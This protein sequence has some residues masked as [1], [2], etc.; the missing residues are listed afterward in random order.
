MTELVQ[1]WV[2]GI[3]GV[4][5]ITGIVMSATPAGRVKRVLC[6]VCGMAMIVTLISPVIA[7]DYDSFSQFLVDGNYGIDSYGIILDE[8]NERL[9]RVIIQED[10]SAYILD[11]ARFMGIDELSVTINT[12]LTEDGNWYPYEAWIEGGCTDSEM[13]ELSDYIEAD[14]GI[15]PERQY[16]SSADE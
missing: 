6:L 9:T 11:K 2:M 16:W 4:S 3:C 5:L 7:F 8:E 1:N 13:S 12:E 10:V 15:P 14:F